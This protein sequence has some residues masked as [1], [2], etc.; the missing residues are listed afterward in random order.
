MAKRRQS[1]GCP[2]TPVGMPWRVAR[3]SREGW[4]WPVFGFTLQPPVFGCTEKIRCDPNHKENDMAGK[5]KEPSFWS[6]F[7]DGLAAFQDKFDPLREL[8][9]WHFADAERIKAEESKE[10]VFGYE[11]RP[12]IGL[13]LQIGAK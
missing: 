9:E 13:R 8:L 12:I 5:I 3:V 7:N 1:A 4:P 10:A 6:Q 2:T 11:R